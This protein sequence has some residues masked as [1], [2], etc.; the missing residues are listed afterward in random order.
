[1]NNNLCIRNKLIKKKKYLLM[2]QKIKANEKNT[3]KTI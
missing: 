2:N 3:Y 1:M